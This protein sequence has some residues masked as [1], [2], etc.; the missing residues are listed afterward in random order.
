MIKSSY[1]TLLRAAAIPTFAAPRAGRAAAGTPTAT[2]LPD[3]R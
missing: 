3:Q 2:P 1:P